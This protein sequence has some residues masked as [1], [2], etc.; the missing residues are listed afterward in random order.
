MGLCRRCPGCAVLAVYQDAREQTA[1]KV[2]LLMTAAA[3]GPT[4]GSTTE[5][6]RSDR[7][8]ASTWLAARNCTDR[9]RDR[10]KCGV[11]GAR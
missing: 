7:P 2:P 9:A 3:S 6:V 8:H 11:A 5:Y 10:G 4:N 1:D